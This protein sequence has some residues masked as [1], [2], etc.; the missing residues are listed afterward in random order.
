MDFVGPQALPA[1]LDPLFDILEDNLPG[2]LNTLI[3]NILSY[4]FLLLSSLVSFLYS[5][6]TW[7]PWEWDTQAILPPLI[8]ALVAYY[9]LY[10]MYRTTGWMIRFVIRM[11][12]Y[13]VLVAIVFAG[14]GWFLGTNGLDVNQNNNGG[15][16]GIA[17]ELIN[18]HSNNRNRRAAT[19]HSR[20]AQSHRFGA[21]A[22]ASKPRPW[23]TF[24]LHRQWQ[25]MENGARDADNNDAYNVIHQVFMTV[26]RAFGMFDGATGGVIRN[27]A[28]MV[29]DKNGEG[30]N[31]D[32]R[33][34]GSTNANSNSKTTSK[35]KAKAST[36]KR[37]KSR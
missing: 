36:E 26:T 31:N 25:Y 17:R 12:E 34:R 4:G 35:R 9:V 13:T 30:N 28:E 21:S 20:R 7:K 19:S 37:T 8:S 15:F 6:P 29:A 23:D 32:N 16:A 5:L 1:F 3:Y 27:L 11:V 2:P 18:Q 14:V 24:E 33:D 22:T 10:S